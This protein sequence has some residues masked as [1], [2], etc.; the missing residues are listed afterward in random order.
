MIQIPVSSGPSRTCADIDITNDNTVENNEDFLV[1]FEIHPDSNA[2]AGVITS[3]R[4]LIIDD[5]S[6]DKKIFVFSYTLSY[7]CCAVFFPSC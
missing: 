6:K 2:N 1:S 4:V 3:T 5:D 7:I